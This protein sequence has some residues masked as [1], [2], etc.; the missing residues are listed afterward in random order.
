MQA[1]EPLTGSG[2]QR[3]DLS[4]SALSPLTLPSFPQMGQREDVF[5]Q[6]WQR[7]GS[8]HKRVKRGGNLLN[9]LLYGGSFQYL[10]AASFSTFLLRQGHCK[11]QPDSNPMGIIPSG[12]IP[13][14]EP[15]SRS[16]QSIYNS[17]VQ[18]GFR[19]KRGENSGC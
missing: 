11:K 19:A 7:G 13:H 3:V 16:V 15:T 8:P 5:G 14:W 4:L 9:T 2:W 18:Q 6:A 1:T 17:L 10:R 12:M